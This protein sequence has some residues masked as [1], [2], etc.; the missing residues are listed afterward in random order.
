MVDS[1]VEDAM[2]VHRILV[3]SSLLALNLAC[4][5]SSPFTMN[6]T[7]KGNSLK[8]GDAI[9]STGA[10][11][12]GSTTMNAAVV[13]L[14]NASGLCGAA[15][16]GRQPK[17]S[18]FIT[19]YLIDR[20]ANTPPSD[21]GTY[22]ICN[23]PYACVLTTKLAYAEYLQTDANCQQVQSSFGELGTIT[24]TSIG[25]GDVNGNFDIAFRETIGDP[26]SDHVTGSFTAKNCSALIP[27]LSNS[28][29]G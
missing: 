7:I 1:S 25:N 5:G 6:G 28:T 24:V 11:Q 14:S 4:G 19:F 15:S 21:A 12:F 2:P 3:G 27:A 13:F 18:Q 23:A 22:V 26:N 10:I 16:A 8:A 17:S 20:N 29:C 9:S